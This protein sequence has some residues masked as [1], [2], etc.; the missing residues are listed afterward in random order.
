MEASKIG[1]WPGLRERLPGLV[2][3]GVSVA[4]RVDAFADELQA[5]FGRIL[6]RGFDASGDDGETRSV[7]LGS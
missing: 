5:V 2:I 3:E 6:E 7:E 1:R 4:A